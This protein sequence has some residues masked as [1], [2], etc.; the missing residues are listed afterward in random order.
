[1]FHA[2]PH[3]HFHFEE[4]YA[5]LQAEHQTPLWVFSWSKGALAAFWWPIGHKKLHSNFWKIGRLGRYRQPCKDQTRRLSCGANLIGPKH[6]NVRSLSYSI[7]FSSCCR[8]LLFDCPST[9]RILVCSSRCRSS[10]MLGL[11]DVCNN[12]FVM[13]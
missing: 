8:C 13:P 11:N 6:W 9:L 10:E 12:L 1:M 2:I 3:G 7:A 4:I 5:R